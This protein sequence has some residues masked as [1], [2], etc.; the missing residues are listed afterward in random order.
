MNPD[1]IHSLLGEGEFSI[2]S[3]HANSTIPDS[4]LVAQVLSRTKPKARIPIETPEYRPS[5]VET[6][7]EPEITIRA[8]PPQ[9][10]SDLK[11]EHERR[12][13]VQVNHSAF[14]VGLAMLFMAMSFA[15]ISIICGNQICIKSTMLVYFAF[16]FVL[17]CLNDKLSL[18]LSL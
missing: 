13:A 2:D 12:R 14:Y 1:L 3:L 6:T 8:T 16:Y 17:V 9:Y 5:P 18:P 15:M 7:P 4:K 11:V 10:N